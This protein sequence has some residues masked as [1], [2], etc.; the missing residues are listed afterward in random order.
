MTLKDNVFTFYYTQSAVA[1]NVLN[2]ETHCI[3]TLIYFV[4]PERFRFVVRHLNFMLIAQLSV[5]RS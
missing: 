1:R 5:Q 2:V 4:K 3:R